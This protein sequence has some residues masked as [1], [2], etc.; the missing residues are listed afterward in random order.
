MSPDDP[1]TRE[2]LL[3]SLL[4]AGDEHR[5][6]VRYAASLDEPHPERPSVPKAS[7]AA[8][9]RASVSSRS[10]EFIHAAANIP[11]L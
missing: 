9:W 5:L 11:A 10:L 7:G 8:A 2:D 3:A 4:A 6:E 1:G